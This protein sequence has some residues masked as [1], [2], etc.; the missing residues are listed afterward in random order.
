MMMMQIMA[1]VS[2][3]LLLLRG[4]HSLAPS[5]APSGQSTARLAS[6]ASLASSGQRWNVAIEST[7]LANE[8]D[9]DLSVLSKGNIIIIIITIIITIINR[10]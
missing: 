6:L 3:L 4:A 9:I 7:Q 10:E 2:P 5:G 8:L 1:L